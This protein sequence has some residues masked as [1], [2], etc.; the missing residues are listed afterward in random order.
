MTKFGQ[1]TEYQQATGIATI[2]FDRPEA[3]SKCGACGA[4]TQTG[5]IDLKADC[6]VGD[7][8]RVEMPEGRCLTATAITYVVPLV[9]L[10]LGLGLGWFASNGSDGFTLLGAMVGLGISAVI[11]FLVDRR[12]SQKPAWTPHIT[13]VFADKP[14]WEDIGCHVE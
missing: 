7:W 10:L 12:V 9:G 3:C 13:E 4:G 1:V 14:T 5:T 8:V 6:N 2:V 11:L